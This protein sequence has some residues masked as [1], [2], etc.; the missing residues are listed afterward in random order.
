MAD[1]ARIVKKI[2]IQTVMQTNSPLR[3]GSGMTDDITDMLIL[4][5]KQG[6]AFIPATSLAGV[7]RSELM[8]MYGEI[9]V[10][11]LF[12][13]VKDNGQ[14]SMINISDI[15]LDADKDITRLIHRDGVKIDEITG[16][17]VSGAKY[18]FEAIDRGAEGSLFLEITLRQHDEDNVPFIDYTHKKIENA[19]DEMAATIADL[20]TSG[21]KIGSLTTKGYGEIKSVERAKCYVFDFKEK[22]HG[23]MWLDYLDGKLPKPW[24][25]GNVT[26]T[27]F[28]PKDFHM[29]IDLAL[30]GSLIVRDYDEGNFTQQ[31]IDDNVAAIQMQSGGDY[32]IPGTSVKGVLKNRAYDILS[33]IKKGD[34][35]SINNILNAIMGYENKDKNSGL[36]SRLY[37][38]DIYIQKDTMHNMKQTRNRIDR[39]T[40]GT[41]DNALFSDEPIWQSNKNNI[42]LTMKLQVKNC[43]EIEAG[44]MLLL[45]KDLWLGNLAIGGGKSIGRGT[46]QGKKCTIAYQGNNFTIQQENNFSVQG[47]KDI[48][49]SYVQK[50]VGEYNGNA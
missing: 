19:Y 36:R 48:L 43:H 29:Q 42:G 26:N 34:E 12:G 35:Q 49:E 23:N 17:G 38:S 40:G 47:N 45:L 30:K 14:Q 3:I 6:K 4:K 50:L 13:N 11:K 20:L 44:I 25:I 33:I 1:S 8:N 28:A 21:I 7:L 32:I 41:I 37:V 39:F 15:V 31:Q 46:L 24:Y 5:N 27:H 10:D 18:D 16:V 22:N 2:V 9:P